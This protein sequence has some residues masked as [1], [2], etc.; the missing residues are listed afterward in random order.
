MLVHPLV[1]TPAPHRIYF[2]LQGILSALHG[3]YV[4]LLH[5]PVGSRRSA[6]VC[7]I[8]CPEC[9]A[10]KGPTQMWIPHPAVVQVNQPPC[11]AQK[12][13][14]AAVVPAQAALWPSAMLCNIVA[15]GRSK[16]AARH[17]L[18]LIL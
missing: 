4:V 8:H 9:A 17:V 5:A 1:A 16:V 14:A 6:T 15:E 10:N 2:A 13:G 3:L 18:Q 12:H 7:V 11:H